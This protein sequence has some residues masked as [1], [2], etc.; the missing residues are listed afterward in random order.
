MG[1]VPDRAGSSVFLLILE[2]AV[3]DYELGP[4]F[5]APKEECLACQQPFPLFL[6]SGRQPSLENSWKTGSGKLFKEA[7]RCRP[8]R[9]SSLA[10]SGAVKRVCTGFGCPHAGTPQL[11]LTGYARESRGLT[12]PSAA[13]FRSNS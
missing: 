2:Q 9:R 11:V 5:L 12:L 6:S 8:N 3:T 1:T 7:R 13:N 4:I 10:H